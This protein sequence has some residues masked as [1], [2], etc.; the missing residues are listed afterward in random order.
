MSFMTDQDEMGA[1]ICEADHFL[2]DGLDLQR[3]GMELKS[4]LEDPDT[5]LGPES[6]T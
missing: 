3:M 4:L 5:I 1:L 6:G 2:V